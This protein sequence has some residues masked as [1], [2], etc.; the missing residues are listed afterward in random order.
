MS[1]NVADHTIGQLYGSSGS[2][3]GKERIVLLG[4][5]VLSYISSSAPSCCA[6]QSSSTTVGPGSAGAFLAK[7]LS[8]KSWYLRPLVLRCH[9]PA[10]ILSRCSENVG[11]PWSSTC[12]YDEA[13]DPLLG[14]LTP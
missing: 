7:L 9:I 10:S 2:P 5:A 14:L 11:V 12:E 1:R 6:T 13:E 3:S 4:S 8:V